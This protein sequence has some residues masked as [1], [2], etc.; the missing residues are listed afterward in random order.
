MVTTA[1]MTAD[2]LYALPDERRGELFA[3]EMRPMPPV[4]FDHLADTGRLILR[5]GAF[6]EL[7]NLGVVGPEGGFRL[8]QNPDTV[9]APDLAYIRTENVPPRGQRGGFQAI[10]PDLVA[11]VLSPSNTASEIN[12]KVRIYLD[13]GVRLVWVVD[14]RTRTV[15]VDDATGVARMLGLGDTLDGGAVLPGFA[16]PLAELVA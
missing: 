1:L 6:V 10:V 4:D 2:E 5:V 12:E 14:P 13:A 11:E 8:G 7:H 16:L 15:S 9:L 3:G